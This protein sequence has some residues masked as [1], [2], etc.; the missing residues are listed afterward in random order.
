[1]LLGLTLIAFAVR[2]HPPTRTI[3]FESGHRL[4]ARIAEARLTPSARE[5]VGR[6]L[7]GE[8]LTDAAA[9]ADQI[10]ASRLST[11]PLH[12]VNI[13]RDA[14]GY[15]SVA[16]CPA[17]RCLIGAITQYR[18]ALVDPATT[19]VD[20]AE[21]LRFLVHFMG[22]L[23]QPLH[24]SDRDD[25]GG[26]LTK[27]E[28]AGVGTTNLHKVWDGQLIEAV[29][30]TEEA[31]WNH[32]Q[33][34]METL[35]LEAMTQGTVVDW[36]MEGHALAREAY[37][38]PPTRRLRQDYIQKNIAVVDLAL[39]KAGVRLAAVLNSAFAGYEPPAAPPA[40]ALPPGTLSDT[41]ARSHI[42]DSATVVGVV[43]TVK[44]VR[45]GNIY[46][47]FGADYPHQTLSGAILDP[48][49]PALLQLDSLAGKRVAIR[50]VI[51]LY[52]GTPEILIERHDQIR[53]LD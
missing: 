49:D 13:P 17:G 26:N 22:D 35:D 29:Y 9:W 46:L 34:L 44:R 2:P 27:V 15:D 47:N 51:R 7:G 33:Q 42:G 18:A 24:V 25:K 21:A 38:F 11:A 39:I 23:H 10:R 5:A 43:V 4:V 31:H 14:S 30:P 3:W 50:G 48:Q 36:A 40:A 8:T 52:R 32:L 28:F 19:T 12:Y 20:R 6:I 53:R 1:M 16:W 37:D 41:E 45:S